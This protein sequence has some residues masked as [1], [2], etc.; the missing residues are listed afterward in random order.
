MLQFVEDGKVVHIHYTLKDISGRVLESSGQG[1][2][3]AYLHGASNIVSG[4][5]RQ[6]FG[7]MIGAELDVVVEPEEGYGERHDVSP[8]QI[9]R[10]HITTQ[11]VRVG[12][13]LQAQT[14]DGQV[15]TLW[16]T[17]VQPDHIVVDLNHPMAGE[18]LYFSVRVMDI[19]DATKEELAHGHP[20]GPGGHRHE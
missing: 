15:V 4:L 2:P 10:A 3:M 7:S 14:G 13:P 12:M 8:Q 1:A 5:E 16:V 18:T 6:L 17:D 19:R 20:S 11:D 9:P